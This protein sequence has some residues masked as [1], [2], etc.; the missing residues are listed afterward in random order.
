[1]VGIILRPF[2]FIGFVFIV[3][4]YVLAASVINLVPHENWRMR[5]LAKLIGLSSR[6]A[7]DLLGVRVNSSVAGWPLTLDERLQSPVNY[8]VVANHL[9]YLDIL[10]IA[11]KMPCAFVTSVEMHETP[12]L[13]WLTEIGAC[14]FVE[15]RSRDK[16][17]DEIA[18]IRRALECGLNVCVF[19]EATTTNG[20]AVLRFRRPL[21]AAAIES[22]REVLPICLNYQRLDGEK[23]AAGNRDLLFWY[24]EAEFFSHLWNLLA[25]RRVDVSMYVE[26][27]VSTSTHT[28]Q[29]ISEFT[30]AQVSQHYMS[31]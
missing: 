9:S 11:A 30:H 21:Y 26:S 28:P 2:K 12:F 1:M 19:P 15:R 17:P 23:I 4:G 25:R 8:F 24:G 31:L 7:L 5:R 18:E 27:P 29:T 20:E 10:I 14:I 22:G 13:G 3:V 6:L 16:L